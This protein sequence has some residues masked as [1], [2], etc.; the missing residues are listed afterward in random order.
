MARSLRPGQ[1]LSRLRQHARN[2]LGVIMTD[3]ASQ[4]QVYRSDLIDL[5]DRYYD[6]EQ[7]DDLME[8]ES[9]V[10]QE[11]YVAVRKRKPRIIYNVAKLVTNKVAAKLVGSQTFPTFSVEDDDDDT[12]FFRTVLKGC[13]FR[14]KLIEPVKRALSSGAC[15]VRY[16]L[17]NGSVQ[18]E[19]AQSKYCYP[20]FDA[21][22]ELEEVEI[23]YLFDD[24]S[25][26]DSKG[27]AKEKWYRIILT[28]TADILYDTPEYR[29]GV[30][31]EF[32][33][34][35][36]ADHGLGWVQ[37]EW[38]VTHKEKFGFDGYSLYGDCLGFIDE[39]N[40]SLSQG[41]QAMSYNQ[42]PQLVVKG[43]DEDELDGLV[44]SSQKAWSLGKIG[45][46]E[47]LQTEMAGVEAAMKL[48]EEMRN[49]MLEVIRVCIQDPEKDKGGA[50][51]SGEALKQLNAPLVELVDELRAVFEPILVNLLLKIALTCLHYNALGEDT[52]IETPK[53]YFPSSLDITVAWPP[54]FP[55]TLTDIAQAATAA[56]AL[57]QGNII[58]RESLTRWIAQMIPTVDNVEE[59][60]KKIATQEPLPSPFG[61]FGDGGGM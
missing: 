40:Y 2:H 29:P 26:K 52:I 16:Y 10:D 23:K 58:S 14:S 15:F 43:M 53:G 47:Y 48:R 33:E 17:V 31:P 20:K 56:T 38:L 39:L 27:K 49:R 5:L 35:A 11:D 12:A 18:I 22:G 32:N 61:T 54:V 50:A 1:N 41:S 28:K 34:V 37:G 46:A 60:L 59:E 25:D 36:R 13:K 24:E 21:V 4:A 9:C 7:Y 8:W 30:K 42:E 57:S 51:Q 45:E 55:P 3:D 6:N 44:R 19:Y